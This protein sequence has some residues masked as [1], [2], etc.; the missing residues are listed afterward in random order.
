MAQTERL[1][2]AR[3][4]TL[5]DGIHAAATDAECWP[6]A[7]EGVSEALDGAGVA[8]A[9]GNDDVTAPQPIHVG[10]GFD[11]TFA[12]DYLAR[13]DYWVPQNPYPHIA[14]ENPGK[15]IDTRHHVSDAVVQRT[16]FY[17]EWMRPQGL[18]AGAVGSFHFGDARGPA[19]GTA[20]YPTARSGD[21]TPRHMRLIEIF[22]R[23]IIRAARTLALLKRTEEDREA[24]LD[25]L[26]RTEAGLLLVGALGNVVSSNRRA[27][28]ILRTGDG[29]GTEHGELQAA[30][31]A[32]ARR[33]REALARAIAGSPDVP[34]VA[35]ARPSGAPAYQ[36]LCAPVRRRVAFSDPRSAAI[37]ALVFI[38]DPA[39]RPRAEPDVLAG[40]YDL[41]PAEARLAVAIGRGM[42]LA[43]YAERTER[44]LETGRSL[45]KRVFA[46]TNTRRQG[47][48]VAL[49]GS[50]AATLRRSEGE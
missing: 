3:V 39:E 45:L 47:E 31:P 8:V 49:V 30:H 1:D 27:D 48:L 7:L 35:V 25:A 9:A 40:L 41:T 36:L 24:F 38:T 18:R 44:S 32:A 11:E 23:H 6:V 20:F 17:E 46:K 26:D 22:D 37:H 50:S 19:G 15:L 28:E 13:P 21:F 29:L 14:L 12:A 10:A 42:S 4:L 5:I 34:A 2:E 33:L 16:G 43:E